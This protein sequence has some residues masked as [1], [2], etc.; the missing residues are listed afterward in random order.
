MKDSLK[1]MD[2]YK[3]YLQLT[4]DLVTILER[5]FKKAQNGGSDEY[6]AKLHEFRRHAHNLIEKLNEDLHKLLRIDWELKELE[7]KEKENGQNN[8]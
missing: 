2:I 7:D 3:R 6:K 5:S 8:H 4:A 1:L